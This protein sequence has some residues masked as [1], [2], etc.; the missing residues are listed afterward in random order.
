MQISWLSALYIHLL[1]LTVAE[2]PNTF[3]AEFRYQKYFETKKLRNKRKCSNY[4]F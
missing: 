2:P 4:N 3:I 1:P